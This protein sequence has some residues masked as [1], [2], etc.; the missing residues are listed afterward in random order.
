MLC[1][2]MAFIFLYSILFEST[3]LDRNY[4]TKYDR[5][6]SLLLVYDVYDQ[7]GKLNISRHGRN[8]DG[9]YFVAEKS[10]QKA[11]LLIGYSIADDI[12][13][14]EQF[15]KIYKKP[16]YGFD[17]GVKDIKVNSPLVKFYSECI[18]SDN[19][20]YKNQI[21]NG[22]ISSFDNHIKRLD[23]AKKKIFVKMDIEGAEY[24]VFDDIL[25]YKDNITGYR[26]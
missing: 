6:T 10:F 19:Y 25:K 22:N 2:F 7:S 5:L 13:F 21:S 24:D 15:S 1:L 8:G 20:I 9:G 11:N 12:S 4:K 14:E 18:G 17:C 3:R 26:C 16:S 23:A